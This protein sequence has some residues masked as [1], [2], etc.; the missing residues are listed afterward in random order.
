MKKEFQN[1]FF[2]ECSVCGKQVLNLKIHMKTLAVQNPHQCIFVLRHSGIVFHCVSIFVSITMALNSWFALFV[3]L[4]YFPIRIIHDTLPNVR[5]KNEMTT[6]IKVMSGRLHE[7]VLCGT[8]V[9][10]LKMHLRSH[11]RERPFEWLLCEKDFTQTGPRNMHLRQAHK[12]EPNSVDPDVLVDQQTK[13]N[14]YSCGM[15]SKNYN[16]SSD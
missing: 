3:K 5:N 13:E 16:S 2:D 11:S 1:R 14:E 8:K 7:C 15:C 4:S 12:I 6:R 9:K 10:N